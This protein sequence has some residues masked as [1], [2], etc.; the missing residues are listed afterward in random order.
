MLQRRGPGE[1]RSEPRRHRFPSLVSSSADGAQGCWWVG[2]EE[3]GAVRRDSG[4]TPSPDPARGTPLSRMWSLLLIQLK[5][6][7][8]QGQGQRL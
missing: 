4:E 5:P 6:A 2:V 3:R 8:A 7:G 1:W